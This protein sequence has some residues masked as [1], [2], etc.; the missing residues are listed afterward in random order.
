MF[1]YFPR[2][3]AR[4]EQILEDGFSDEDIKKTCLLKQTE[5][6]LSASVK[7]VFSR[8]YIVAPGENR[9]PLCGDASPCGAV[10]ARPGLVGSD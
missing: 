7:A 10:N 6:S 3:A 9:A 2:F 5:P 8:T 1:V 4:V